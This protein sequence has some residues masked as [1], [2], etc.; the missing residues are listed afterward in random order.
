MA[1]QSTP[2]TIQNWQ[3]GIGA[4]PYVGFGKM[5][6]MD[7]FRKPGIIQAGISLSLSVTQSALLTAIITCEV[8]DTFGNIYT[9]CADGKFFKNGTLAHTADAGI[10]D[11]VIVSDT[12]SGSQ[13]LIIS[14]A[15]TTLD[16]YGVL[17][18]S[19]TYHSA[20]VSGLTTST[21]G[22][23]KMLLGQ[24]N[25]VYIANENKLASIVGF[26]FNSPGINISCLTSG[27]PNNR[28]V[29]SICELNRY[30]VISTTEGS[31]INS[32]ARLYFMD[33]GL[34]NGTGTSFNLS[35]GVDIPER[36][37]NQL[38]NNNNRLLFF[39]C[40]TGTIYTSNTTTYTA[41][42]VIPNRL[43]TQNY[44]TYPNG[45]CILNNEVLFGVGGAFNSAYDVVYGVYS[46][47]GNSLMTKNT[48]SSG[49]YGQTN[50]VAIGSIYPYNLG[51]YNVTWQTGGSTY[52]IDVGNT[53]IGTTFKCWFE[54]PF[55][56]TGSSI[57]PRT[58]QTVQFNTGN[59]MVAGQG[60][61]MWYRLATNSSWTYFAT[62]SYDGTNLNITYEPTTGLQN[63]FVAGIGFNS[64]NSRFPVTGTT[65]IQ[66]KVAFDTGNA[67][68]GTNIE[69]QSIILI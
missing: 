19:P 34:V 17:D 63:T 48:I 51:V 57:Q 45:C 31:G 55:Y 3:R 5:V 67:V 22:Y 14:K 52:G 33:R 20:W 69:L 32:N 2:I 21:N 6:G 10:H 11:M 39:G 1:A 68:F 41:I 50:S 26:T 46:L 37:V 4:S 40:D 13:Y 59:G 66:I 47:R 53:S 49:E 64:F 42:V 12:G 65:N 16:V 25:V 36:K 60:L 28:I 35:I 7:I 18:N 30:I 8:T 23:K 27:L 29:Q 58:F 56:E 61:K 62:F 38:I 43:P 24:D 44:I 54:S 9:G 15:N